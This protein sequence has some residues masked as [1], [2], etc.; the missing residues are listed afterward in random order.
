M[1]IMIPPAL[2]ETSYA[3]VV[4]QNEDNW[5]KN[6][7]LYGAMVENNQFSKVGTWLPAETAPTFVI[8]PEAARL[9]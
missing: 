5:N 2:E 1:F 8:R 6:R 7:I 3:S 9:S 4:F